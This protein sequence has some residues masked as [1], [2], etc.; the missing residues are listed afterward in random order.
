MQEGEYAVLIVSDTGLGI[1]PE[2]LD[3]IFEPF[4]TRKKMG[5]S[6]TG[7]GMAVVWGTVQDHNGQINVQSRKGAGT[8]FEIFFPATRQALSITDQA[9]SLAALAGQGEKILVVDDVP[10]Q[11]EITSS[12]LE[13]LGYRVA[14]V[15]GGEAALAYLE[16]HSADLMILDMIMTPG[17][18]GLETY[19]RILARHP[20][21]K[22]VIASGFAENERVRAAQELG[23]GLYIRKPFTLEKIGRAV[24]MALGDPPPSAIP[25]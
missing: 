9:F 22:A 18:D 13:E 6:G 4:Y 20:D 14:T 25:E 21:Q 2:D 15:P 12:I 10:A 1:A 16:K 5:R 23:A 24:K 17:M 19:R 3:R 7:L 11:R 8:T